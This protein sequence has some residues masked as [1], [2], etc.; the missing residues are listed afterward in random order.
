LNGELGWNRY[1]F[2]HKKAR[3]FTSLGFAS[4]SIPIGRILNNNE[5]ESLEDK[6]T[7]FPE[8]MVKS[9]EAYLKAIG[10]NSERTLEFKLGL[11]LELN[12]HKK[13]SLRNQVD[14]YFTINNHE[15]S[16]RS[17]VNMGQNTSFDFSYKTNNWICRSFHSIHFQVNK[18][19][20]IYGG[21]RFS[22]TPDAEYNFSSQPTQF[23]QLSQIT[24]GSSL[25]F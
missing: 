25:K 11:G 15:F 7:E 4:N 5:L 20:N 22:L 3:L 6:T 2:S 8:M 21:I 9:N 14:G 1:L 18:R 16:N 23:I 17:I 24:M 13:V 12:I 19:L 10:F